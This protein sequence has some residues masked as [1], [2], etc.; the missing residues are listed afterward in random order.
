MKKTSNK[1]TLELTP[2][3]ANVL[4]MALDAEI[5]RILSKGD[6]DPAKDFFPYYETLVSIRV[7][8]A[9]ALK[10]DDQK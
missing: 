10:G 9:D 5:K 6:F 2:S 8:L 1:I 4:I 7:N 3:S